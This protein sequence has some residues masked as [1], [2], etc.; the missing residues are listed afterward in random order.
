MLL[1]SNL[2]PICSDGLALLIGSWLH[3][4]AALS[5]AARGSK[6]ATRPAAL[7]PGRASPRDGA[8]ALE[9]AACRQRSALAHVHRGEALG[10][11]WSVGFVPLPPVWTIERTRVDPFMGHPLHWNATKALVLQSKCKRVPKTPQTTP[12]RQLN[13]LVP[14]TGKGSEQWPINCDAQV[15][16]ATRTP[17][18]LLAPPHALRLACPCVIGCL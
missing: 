7:M 10:S 3:E 5:K 15:C 13:W 1:R 18:A 8:D 16:L 4:R 17:H 2:L 14:P 6:L 9:A 12:S 11:C